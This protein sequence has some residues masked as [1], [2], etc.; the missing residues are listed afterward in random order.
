M[1]LIFEPLLQL[2]QSQATMGNFVLLSLVHLSISAC[3]ESIIER[4]LGKRDDLRLAVVLK[5]SIPPWAMVSNRKLLD[6]T[7]RTYRNQ[8]ALEEALSFPFVVCT[9]A[10][11]LGIERARHTGHRPWKRMGSWPRPGE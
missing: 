8:V 7:S 11:E 9:L 3:Q 1:W 2:L 10:M 5:H 6:S 4:I